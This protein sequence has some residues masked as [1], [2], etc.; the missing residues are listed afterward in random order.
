[1]IIKRAILCGHFYYLCPYRPFPANLIRLKSVAIYFAW[2]GRSDSAENYLLNK[3]MSA[4]EAGISIGI[5]YMS[6]LAV[7]GHP[8]DV[9]VHGNGFVWE[10][11][12]I[13]LSV[14]T[15]KI[16][17]V[18]FSYKFQEPSI[19]SYLELRYNKNTFV[20]LGA[21]GFSFF[22]CY[23]HMMLLSYMTALSLSELSHYRIG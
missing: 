22:A 18:P 7:I 8:A 19:Y 2:K 6:S 5:T 23:V 11:G 16:F 14:V 21:L 9:Y 20:M 10:I 15:L 13:L 4:W 17:A 12:G 1:M 3:G